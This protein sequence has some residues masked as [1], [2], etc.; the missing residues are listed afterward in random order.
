MQAAV[1]AT[2]TEIG[3]LIGEDDS[4]Q[5]QFAY[6]DTL[7]SG[8]PTVGIGAFGTPGEVNGF[9]TGDLQSTSTVGVSLGAAFAGGA[10]GG[11]NGVYPYLVDFFPNGVQAVSGFVYSDA[12][13]API[14]AATVGVI[15]HGVSLGTASTGFN[16]YYYI[17]TA[18]GGVPTGQSVLAYGNSPDA[19]TLATSA[20]ADNT[21]GVNLYGDALTGTTSDTTYLQ[22]F[23]N[24][25]PAF[26]TAAG[27]NSQALS[28]VEHANGLYLTATGA[29]FTVDEALTAS[30]ADSMLVIQTTGI[31]API[32]IGHAITIEGSNFLEL[33]A[34]GSLTI[35]APISVTGAGVVDLADGAGGLSFDLGPTGFGGS[36][37]YAVGTGEGITGQALT[38]NGTSY[39]LLY[40]M[41]DVSSIDGS[42]GAFA[43]AAPVTAT[44][45][46]TGAV[47]FTF[48]GT[49]E[50]LGN[51]ISGLT[52]NGTGNY[53]G[54]FGELNTGAV[55][56]DIGLSGGSITGLN[57]V[58]ALV[59]YNELG[60]T[61]TDVIATGATVTSTGGA[62]VGGLA[63]ASTGTIAGSISSNTVENSAFGRA[64]GGLVG[65]VGAVGAI[66]DSSASGTVSGAADYTGGLAGYNAGAIA[67][68]SSSS[69]NVA[70]LGEYTGGLVG[71]NAA[72]GTI[73][74]ASAS[75][76]RA[77]AGGKMYVG[78]LAGYNAGVI[79]G[80][81]SH[82]RRQRGWRRLCRRPGRLQR[83]RHGF[84]RH[85]KRDHRQRR[86]R[87]GGR[88]PGRL[89][90][91]R[92][93]LRLQ[94]RRHG[95]QRRRRL[96]HR[97]PRRLQRRG[98]IHHGQLRQRDRQRRHTH[99]TGGLAGY[100]AGSIGSSFV[101]GS[102]GAASGAFI[103]GLA[104]YNAGTIS[105][106][107]GFYA[108]IGPRATTMSAASW[109]YNA[110]SVSTSWSSGAVSGTSDLAG[111]IGK[112]AGGT[113]TD[114]YW[115]EVTSGRT[116]ATA[117]AERLR[118]HH[119]RR[120][121]RDTGRNPRVQATY[122]GFNFTTTWTIIPGTSRP[123]FL[124]VPAPSTPPN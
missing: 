66:S 68:A 86:R 15:A 47:D 90:R 78:G 116:N 124:L 89:Q 9:S 39:D 69:S 20:G 59:G 91:R 44:G 98:L 17:V 100:N 70:A 112:Q 76:N 50:G 53:V 24:F 72:T 104:G 12:G 95:R 35:E 27:G 45:T 75:G 22:L 63:G 55:V 19:A 16:G 52:I 119:R 80:L 114:L 84:Q 58:G 25:F 67:A 7:T 81:V 11:Q 62:D 120:W 54:L 18:A 96:R 57:Y 43:L 60:A 64:T 109:A 38:I 42:P 33:H 97:R 10:A 3:G 77:S 107:Y 48:L 36:L 65:G 93:G 2:P 121:R 113:L 110:G 1:G 108:G 102:V 30:A 123:I 56:R 85:R 40:S 41:A 111:S 79:S 51:S 88:R 26:T 74:D 13:T 87:R 73:A 37:R 105:N 101:T 118:R 99:Y 34:A 32:V 21:S 46:L 83:R 31:N 8:Q 117:P 92:H 122:A 103:G 71:Y 49:L 115:D 6:W 94:R 29:S 61:I 4:G 28:A 82:E 23:S 5:V 14:A 106:T